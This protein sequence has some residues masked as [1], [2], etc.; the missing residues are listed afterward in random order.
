MELI[1]SI[2]EKNYKKYF[3]DTKNIWKA[4]KRVLSF[5]YS[6]L[7]AHTLTY[8]STTVVLALLPFVG[9]WLNSKIIDV[10]VELVNNEAGEIADAQR[11]FII[12]LGAGIAVSAL[13]NLLEHLNGNS[14]IRIWYGLEKDFTLKITRKFAYL[15][16][17]HYEDPEMRDLLN[18]V[19][20]NNNRAQ[21]FI[22]QIAYSI[23]DTVSI[24]SATAILI[25]FSPLIIGILLVTAIPTLIANVIYGR[26]MWGIWGTKGEEGRDFYWTR[27][28]LTD[29]RSLME[30]RIFKTRDYL[31]ERMN[32]LHTQFQQAQ[33]NVEKKK[34]ITL[35]LFSIIRLL[36]R[37]TAT[38]L[39]ALATIAGKITVGQFNFYFSAA[40]RLQ[41]GFTNIIRRLAS[42][43][44][45][46]LYV[47]DIFDFLDLEEKIIPGTVCLDKGSK[48]PLIEFKNVTFN[49]PQGSKNGEIKSKD[50]E[51]ALKNIN[52]TIN[53]G[54]HIAIVGKN[55][56]GKTTLIKLLLRFY[57][58]KEGDIIINGVEL[59]DIDLSS[60][61]EKIAVLFQDFNFYHFTA[62]ENIAV[63]DPKKIENLSEIIE[64][65]K[66][67]DAHGFIEK[68]EKGYN[69]I[70]E[71]SFKG[72]VNPSSGQKQKIA[73]ARTFFKDPPILILDEPTSSIDPTAE[74][75]IFE[76]LFDFAKN[77][78]VIIISH[79][80]STVR[81]A[82][83]IIVLDEGEIVEQ[84][85]HKELMEITDGK[86]KLA[87]ELQKKGYE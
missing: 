1:T 50:T 84:G 38:I 57:D 48:P 49:Y 85:S 76:K 11:T 67:A 55:G 34:R 87:F 44:E 23:R 17:E 12:L 72:G 45:E 14:E 68:Y 20:Q 78:T 53:P 42:I 28:Y 74:Y 36:G 46:G 8:F 70:L 33:L 56:A 82:S 39:I 43:Y 29:E 30:L 22:N 21:R 75:E 25:A 4:I 59:K 81:N 61:Y 86:Y 66:N 9:V 73:L 26:R 35:F 60:W 62:R 77:K 71:K 41:N 31:L 6:I 37:A 63:G 64:A 7:P 13:S 2:K 27:H 5:V 32:N 47:V 79:R 54:E 19:S 65:A 18:K 10:L 83:R 3:E 52:L 69:Q 15:D 80:F 24:I 58:I 40:S 16:T 51:P